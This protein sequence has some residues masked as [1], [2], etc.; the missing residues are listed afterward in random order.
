MQQLKEYLRKFFNLIS[1]Q[2]YNILMDKNVMSTF[3][4]FPVLRKQ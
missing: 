2:F 4:H 3:S 1:I